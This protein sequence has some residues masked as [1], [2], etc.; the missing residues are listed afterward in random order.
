MP[1]LRLPIDLDAFLYALAVLSFAIMLY[2]FL[3]DPGP[4]PLDVVPAK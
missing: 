1:R 4:R 2:V 3:S